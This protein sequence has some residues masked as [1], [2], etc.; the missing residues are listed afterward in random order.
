MKMTAFWQVALIGSAAALLVCPSPAAARVADTEPTL[1]QLLNIAPAEDPVRR[2]VE[3]DD[4]G[5]A[6]ARQGDPLVE[7][8]RQMRRASHLIGSNLDPGLDTQ[9]L[10]ES[11]MAR[12][13]KLIEAAEQN[14]ESSSSSSSAGGR[15]D[16]A[17]QQDTGS[18]K[19][20]KRTPGGKPGDPKAAGAQASTSAMQA[21]PGS[22]SP[23]GKQPGQDAA[24]GPM[25]QTRV[26]W[27]ALPPRLRDQLLQGV[28]ERSSAIYHRLTDAYFRRLAE[29]SQ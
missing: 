27:G 3:P 28:N 11:I 23:G 17:R 26:E 2:R 6:G 25:R 18:Q 21:N 10:Q 22:F 14:D 7:V 5:D 20:A 8:S 29:E 4:D 9:R 16:S 12:L 24:A 13:D 1:D 15:Q 19:N